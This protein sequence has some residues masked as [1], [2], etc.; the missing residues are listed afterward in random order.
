MIDW[1]SHLLDQ[2]SHF[3]APRKGLLP[4]VG[5]LLIVINLILQFIPG[6]GWFAS[7]NILLHLGAI[8]AIFGFLLGQAL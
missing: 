7:S 5:I 6:L 1:L 4:L 8:V 3:L 2:S